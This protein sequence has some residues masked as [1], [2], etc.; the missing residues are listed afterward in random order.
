M[1][2]KSYPLDEAP[3]SSAEW[4]SIGLGIGQGIVDRGGFP[5]RLGT[6]NDVN[7]TVVIDVDRVTGKNLALL[8]GIAH[9]M[10]APEILTIPAVA[11]TTIY[12]VGLEYDP[13]RTQEAGG[14]ILL[15]VWKAPGDY[16]LGKNRLVLYR[17]TRQPSQVLTQAVVEQYRPRAS[18]SMI[19]STESHLPRAGTMLVDTQVT[20]RDSGKVWRA[21]SDNNGN[22]SWIELPQGVAGDAYATGS[23]AIMRWSDGRGGYVE[24]PKL[25]KEVSNKQYVDG[26]MKA[27]VDQIPYSSRFAEGLALMSRHSDGRGANVK[28]PT[29]GENTANKQYVDGKRWDGSRITTGVVPWERVQ[30]STHAYRTTQSGAV[31]TVSVNSSGRFMRFSSALKYKTGLRPYEVDPR[32]LLKLNPVTFKRRTDDGGVDDR[33]EL[34]F[35]ADWVAPV[36]PEAALYMTNEN[37]VDEIES[38]DFNAIT[39][40]QQRIIQWQ[41]ERLDELEARIQKLEGGAA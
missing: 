23:T 16:R 13:A 36:L 25:A 19:V 41:A 8:D 35:I 14:P 22:M 30:G 39:A 18:P 27:A 9:E 12:E 38:L 32:E 4:K 34:G 28:N 29:E 24:D 1:T 33:V 3:M 11:T 31:Y 20:A 6:K 15:K 37:G 40:A 7:N 17:V 10:D 2:Q 5:Y 21:H 26:A